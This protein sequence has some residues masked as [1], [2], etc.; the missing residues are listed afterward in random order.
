[1]KHIFLGI[2]F[3]WLLQPLKAQVTPTDTSM[4]SATDTTLNNKVIERQPIQST[5]VRNMYGDLLNDDPKYNKKYPAWIPASGVLIANGSLL[6]VDRFVFNFDF[7]HVS[8]TTWKNNLK[9]GFAW[10]DDPFGVNFIGHPYTGN[11]YFNVA[12]SSGYNYWQSFP[13]A[14]GG[15]LLWEY[16]GENTRPSVNDIIN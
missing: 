3:L 10:D 8:T 11:F 5:P 16:F 14:V 7:S 6:A 12:R 15:S 9:R 1:M 4:S 13:F 2:A